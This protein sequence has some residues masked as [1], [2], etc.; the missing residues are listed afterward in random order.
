MKTITS[1]GLVKMRNRDGVLVGGFEAS[2]DEE[3]GSVHLRITRKNV[4]V[5][6]IMN[7]DVAK[8]LAGL[9]RDAASKAQP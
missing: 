4:D 2:L 7:P 5:V 3:T 6:T 8:D 1:I 9:L